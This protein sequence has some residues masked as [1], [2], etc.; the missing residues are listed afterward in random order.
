VL[1]NNYFT[2]NFYIQRKEATRNF[3]TFE[4]KSLKKICGPAL[5]NNQC[6][7]YKIKALR[8][9]YWSSYTRNSDYKKQKLRRQDSCCAEKERAS[10]EAPSRTIQETHHI[11]EDGNWDGMVKWRMIYDGGLKS[12]RPSLQPTRNSEKSAVG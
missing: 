7:I 10:S 8:G 4:N 3:L 12:F 11:M 9:L 2:C 5:E 1:Q 6:G